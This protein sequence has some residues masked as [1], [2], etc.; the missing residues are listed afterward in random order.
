MMNASTSGRL[1]L[2][3]LG[4]LGVLGAT[5][6][7]VTGAAMTGA[8]IGMNLSRT[9]SYLTIWLDGVEATQDKLKKA[10]TG[11]S[12]FTCSD[13]VGT[14][15]KLKFDII[16]PDKFGRITMVTA[17]IYQKFEADYSHQAEFT[18]FSRDTN[19]PQAQM[20]PKT[21]Y[22]L[23]APGSELKVTDLTGKEVSGVSLKPGMKY[24]LT[25]SVKAD[26]S[27]TAQVYFETK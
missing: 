10:A 20:K 14:A 19:N 2:C 26:R 15:P 4:A 25:L 9:D 8:N 5:G 22:N 23:G 17:S 21:E 27:E 16:D 24:M 1:A 7:S 6:C 11:Y 12:R 18:I 3:V 13:P